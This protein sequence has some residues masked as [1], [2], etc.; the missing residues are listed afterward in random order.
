MR[1][2]RMRKY[3]AFMFSLLLA[4]SVLVQPVSAQAEEP[5]QVHA[6]AAMLID[7]DTGQVLYE[8]NAD[9][10]LG[11]ASMVKMMTEYLLLE[12][13]GEK[14]LSWDDEYT[15]SEYVAQVSKDT[16][17]SNVPLRL[18][19]T[20]NV[21]ELYDAMAIY[22]ANGATI[23]LAEM[24]A[25]T[26]QKF[27]QL[28]KEKAKELGLTNYTFVNSSGLSKEDLKGMHP[29][30]NASQDDNL[31]SARDTAKLAYKLLKDYPEVLETASIPQ[32]IFREGTVDHTEMKNWNWMLPS[33]VYGYEGMTGLKTGSTDFAGYCFTGTAE[34]NGQKL[35][36]VVLDATDAN[37]KGSY[38]ARFVETEKL[39]N[40]GFNQFD[41]QEVIK[42]GETVKG[43]ETVE[44]SK[45]K[46]KEVAIQ[47]GESLVIYTPKAE[48]TNFKKSLSLKGSEKEEDENPTAPLKKGE[49]VGF[50]QVTP[51]KGTEINYLTA[52]EKKQ[53]EV[54][55]KAAESMEKANWFV[56]S[57]R[58]VGSFFSGIWTAA[59]DMVTGWF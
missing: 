26:E 32:K 38:E 6:K 51:E 47:A 59:A 31:M 46:E 52:E 25:G 44:V 18:G 28:M 1:N 10:Q 56:L 29:S 57:M 42:E 40:Y 50:L 19:E 41:R 22:S 9:E 35:I 12:A 17:L 8:K 13:I 37:G 58:A 11:I 20:Y 3:I 33:L 21:R 27:V 48:K 45:G 2:R 53:A 15:V 43:F 14:K 30:S 36:A 55:M 49:V 4:V 34:R 39:L 16:N 5:L 23:A 24:I 54:S 7:A